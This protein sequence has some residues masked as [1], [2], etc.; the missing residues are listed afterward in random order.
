M[1]LTKNLV[2]EGGKLRLEAKDQKDRSVNAAN[3]LSWQEFPVALLFL[4]FYCLRFFLS[5]SPATLTN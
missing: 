5:V 4:Y 1:E 2:F 3:I